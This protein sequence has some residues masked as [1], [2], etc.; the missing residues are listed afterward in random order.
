MK[1]EPFVVDLGVT[2]LVDVILPVIISPF[3]VFMS[4]LT[5]P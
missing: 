2:T 3:D 4:G 1:C 5:E